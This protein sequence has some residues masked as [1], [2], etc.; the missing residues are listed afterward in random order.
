MF[1]GRQT[2]IAY[3]RIRPSL[4]NCSFPIQRMNKNMFT[5]PAGKKIFLTILWSFFTISETSSDTIHYYV[6]DTHCHYFLHV[7]ASSFCTFFCHTRLF[8]QCFFAAESDTPPQFLSIA[9]QI[10]EKLTQR[11][12]TRVRNKNEHV[13]VQNI[14]SITFSYLWVPSYQK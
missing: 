8:L 2:R 6:V 9:I 1:R 5:R 13:L 11:R 3:L 12:T 4:K 14:D 10:S 7:D